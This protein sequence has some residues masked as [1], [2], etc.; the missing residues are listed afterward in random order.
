MCVCVWGGVK[1]RRKGEV[2]T[3]WVTQYAKPLCG[4][5]IGDLDQMQKNMYTRVSFCC[6]HKIV[7]SLL[8]L[9]VLYLTFHFAPQFSVPFCISFFFLLF[10]FF[11]YALVALSVIPLLVVL[12]FILPFLISRALLL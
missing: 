10:F 3:L 7:V 5:G 12:F 1:K 9:I 6:L 8:W 4:D 11:F 2:D